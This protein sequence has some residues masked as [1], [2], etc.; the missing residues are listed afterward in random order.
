[1]LRLWKYC[2]WRS[3][4]ELFIVTLVI[5]ASCT[6]DVKPMFVFGFLR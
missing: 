6:D 5:L 4:I 3:V 1:M 2:E